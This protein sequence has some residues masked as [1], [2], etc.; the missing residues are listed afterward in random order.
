V[1]AGGG[2]RRPSFFRSTPGRILLRLGLTRDFVTEA[3]E[4]V[5]RL[6][7]GGSV[8]FLPYTREVEDVYR[9]SDIV[10]APSQGPEIGRS[11]LEAAACGVAAV[12]SGSTT[13]GGVLEPGVTTEFVAAGVEPLAEALGALLD[14]PGRREALGAAARLHALATFA[15]ERVASLVTAVYERVLE[16]HGLE[17]ER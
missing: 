10:V 9:A 8:R 6:G 2:V 7:L 11:L 14:D 12:G 3:R 16:G 1:V 17:F 15:P 4:L 5:G 13:G